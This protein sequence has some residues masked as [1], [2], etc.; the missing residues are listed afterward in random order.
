MHK[1]LRRLTET[2]KKVVVDRYSSGESMA[3]IYR[4][5]GIT[6]HR[7]RRELESEGLFRPVGLTV[8]QVVEELQ[9]NGVTRE[10]LV[11]WYCI[12][13]R[14][15]V[16]VHELL[17]KHVELTE[18]MTERVL[19]LLNVRKPTE[20]LRERRGAGSKAAFQTRLALL[21]GCGFSLDELSD[22][23]RSGF[24]NR[25]LVE[26]VNSRLV[27]P[28]FTVRWFEK[29]LSP[30][31]RKLSWGE[32]WLRT[33]IES[34]IRNDERVYWNDRSLIA[35][36]E[37]DAHLVERRLAI[38]YNGSYWHSEPVVKANHGSTAVEYHQTKKERCRQNGVTLAF[39]WEGEEDADVVRSFI[40]TGT[41]S[42][43][44][45]RLS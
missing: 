30:V 43:G 38:E 28:I 2:E 1:N 42:E 11:E 20:K 45:T 34:V 12:Q 13:N 15:F 36:Y 39:V 21:E 22:L 18:R 33:V 37:L 5:T 14:S 32:N 4:D 41:L 29:H 9:K 19:E 8:F 25:E 40:T 26:K 6:P 7:Q 44:L 16:E 31:D 35:P 24:S 3:S 23:R 27:E 10:A 17:S